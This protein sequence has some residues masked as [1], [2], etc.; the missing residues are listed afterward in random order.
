MKKTAL[1]CGFR[2]KSVLEE[3]RTLDHTLR[4]RELYPA[5]LRG[6]HNYINK[7]PFQMQVLFLSFFRTHA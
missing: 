5:E 6:Q 2:K 4:R 7:A 1:H 3:I